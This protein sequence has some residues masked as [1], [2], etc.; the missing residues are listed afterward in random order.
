MSFAHLHVHTEY[1]L[2]DG[3]N[4]IKEYV[5]VL[6]PILENAINCSS[7]TFSSPITVTFTPVI[8]KIIL[9]PHCTIRSEL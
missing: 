2:L 7:G 8:F 5:A 3:S 9:N 1:S 4:K 6:Q